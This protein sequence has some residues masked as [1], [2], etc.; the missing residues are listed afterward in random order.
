MIDYITKKYKEEFE[1]VLKEY[2]VFDVRW[3]D[4][5]YL[6]FFIGKGFEIFITNEKYRILYQDKKIVGEYKFQNLII[7][8]FNLY[9]NGK[10]SKL[11]TFTEGEVL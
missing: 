9:K 5:E 8:C 3:N 2:K 1:E 6:D 10:K 7:N 4:W 11:S